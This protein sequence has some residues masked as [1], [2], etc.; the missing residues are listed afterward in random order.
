MARRLITTFVLLA[1]GIVC[2]EPGG[3]KGASAAAP[4]LGGS[5]GASPEIARLDGSLAQLRGRVDSLQ[6]ANDKL[7][8][9]LSRLRQLER[10]LAEIERRVET[11][12]PPERGSEARER[13][14]GHA[15]WLRFEQDVLR[16]VEPELAPLRDLLDHTHAYARAGGGWMNP[17][18]LPNCQDCLIRF[19]SSQIPASQGHPNTGPPE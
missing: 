16:A 15:D 13:R 2:M 6:R 8:R 5:S 17:E 12:A 19:R 10:Q 14:E 9:D 3:R 7:A 11:P 1:L 18:D 4:Q